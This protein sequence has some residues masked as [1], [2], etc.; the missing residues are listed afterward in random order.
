MT[1]VM[2]AR[3]KSENHCCSLR[4]KNNAYSKHSMLPF[5]PQA[6]HAFVCLPSPASA[7]FP[8]LWISFSLSSWITAPTHLS[9]DNSIVTSSTKPILFGFASEEWV[10][11]PV[12]ARNDTPHIH[13]NTLGPGKLPGAC[14]VR[15]N[16]SLSLSHS[17]KHTHTHTPLCPIQGSTAQNEITITQVI[18]LAE[19]GTQPCF[20]VT[21]LYST[22][23]FWGTG[24]PIL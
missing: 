17:V 2:S 18:H 15:L 3:P 9:V 13:L 14:S 7:G 21:N 8:L 11:L 12:C 22:L 10:I 6:S 24:S 20:I 5:V 16:Q 4:S 19:S 23:E 1:Q